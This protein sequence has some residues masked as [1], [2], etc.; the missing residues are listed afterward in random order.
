MSRVHFARE[1]LSPHALFL[2]G[3]FDLAFA[4]LL[5]DG[6][7]VFG[8]LG[9]RTVDEPAILPPANCGRSRNHASRRGSRAFNVA[10]MYSNSSQS[11]A[12]RLETGRCPA[13]VRNPEWNSKLIR[14]QIVRMAN[15]R[16]FRLA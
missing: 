12:L 14:F 10:G 6:V 9:R 13:L 1:H 11:F 3:G 4:T 7:G 5:A 15:A 8:G 16:E 2:P